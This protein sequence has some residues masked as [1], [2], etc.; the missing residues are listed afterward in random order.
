MESQDDHH[1]NP[2]SDQ[3][4]HALVIEFVINLEIT[5]NIRLF[6][7]VV[8]LLVLIPTSP[9]MMG[10]LEKCLVVMAFLHG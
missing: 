9:M 7:W 3:K 6:H 5:L 2:E 10:H 1:G 4:R 8:F